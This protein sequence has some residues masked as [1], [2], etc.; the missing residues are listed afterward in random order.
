MSGST[1]SVPAERSL[2]SKETQKQHIVLIAETGSNPPNPQ[3]EFRDPAAKEGQTKQ[4]FKEH[5]LT[6]SLSLKPYPPQSNAISTPSAHHYISQHTLGTIYS[7]VNVH[8]R[9]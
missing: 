7:S 1:A 3:P 8:V 9:I 5:N 4:T 6:F 2:S